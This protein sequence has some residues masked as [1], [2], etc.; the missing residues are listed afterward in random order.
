MR[1]M[2]YSDRFLLFAN[3]IET[4]STKEFL[5]QDQLPNKLHSDLTF[6]TVLLP[7]DEATKSICLS[8][9]LDFDIIA[10]WILAEAS[11][12]PGDIA[13]NVKSIIKD[14]LGTVLMDINNFWRELIQHFSTYGHNTLR[15]G[16]TTAPF[17]LVLSYFDAWTQKPVGV[18]LANL[19]AD[20]QLVVIMIAYDVLYKL[21]ITMQDFS[22][23]KLY[24]KR[25]RDFKKNDLES[26]MLRSRVVDALK[27]NLDRP[28]D[29]LSDDKFAGTGAIATI[30][31]NRWLNI[32]DHLRNVGYHRAH[33]RDV[34]YRVKCCITKFHNSGIDTA[35]QS[36]IENS[37]SMNELVQCFDIVRLMLATTD[38]SVADLGPATSWE[39]HNVE[40][41]DGLKHLNGWNLVH[42]NDANDRIGCQVF[43]DDNRYRRG[44]R[45][46]SLKPTIA[47]PEQY[48][49][50]SGST[51]FV[52]NKELDF[53][54]FKKSNE[55]NDVTELMKS[56]LVNARE[57]SLSAETVREIATSMWM[58]YNYEG[59]VALMRSSHISETDVFLLASTMARCR[60]FFEATHHDVRIDPDVFFV[61]PNVG[62]L[63]EQQFQMIVSRGIFASK[64]PWD[65]ITLFAQGKE[66]GRPFY[67][68]KPYQITEDVRYLEP[69]GAPLISS[70]P[71]AVDIKIGKA[72]HL[73]FS[74]NFENIM[75]Y[76]ISDN[77]VLL[78]HEAWQR[79]SLI[80]IQVK[81]VLL[82]LVDSVSNTCFIDGNS[83]DRLKF[84][85]KRL[86][87]EKQF[88]H[89]E[90]WIK[91]PLGKK[92]LSK[93][94]NHVIQQPSVTAHFYT[95]NKAQASKSYRSAVVLASL[96]WM[97]EF[98]D[99]TGLM[100]LSL[101]ELL[102]DYVEIYGMAGEL[103]LEEKL[104]SMY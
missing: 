12:R 98:L 90:K 56:I 18:A 46:Y 94:E 50:F 102:K 49:Q 16:S 15:L 80:P 7:R 31:S 4:L 82:N 57:S 37:S 2:D 73:I 6:K 30:F 19:S 72:I 14:D 32:I 93:I 61:V 51:P 97:A 58:K 29:G 23:V 38:L 78:Y 70:Q 41:L 39:Q 47:P 40:I 100:A 81:A 5:F 65:I 95:R 21:G 52:N 22:F 25:A 101:E 20:L 3:D 79:V 104:S 11:K 88:D 36:M 42:I 92:V 34:L 64:D 9:K 28:L 62:T 33:L 96:K 53:V 55:V 45:L 66:A 69:M 91:S 1:T 84:E 35:Y 24:K 103:S 85:I 83:L 26:E 59:K 71:I 99:K 76:H 87:C 27:E 86:S 8:S 74:C 77:I 63:N 67:T 43:E 89:L 54:Y 68:E 17:S 48:Y 10:D 13:A 60:I 75:N 44:V